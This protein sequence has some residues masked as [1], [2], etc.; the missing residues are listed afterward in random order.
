MSTAYR[1]LRPRALHLLAYLAQE[2]YKLSMEPRPLMVTRGAYDEVSGATLTPR[3]LEPKKDHSSVHATGFAFDVRRRYGSGAQ[4]EAFQW[5]LERL[6]ALGLIA[7]TRGKS[8]IHIVASP[9]SDAQP[10]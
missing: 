1:T 6:E 7:W 2:V 4:A 9:R 8:V 3:D 5:T 10:S